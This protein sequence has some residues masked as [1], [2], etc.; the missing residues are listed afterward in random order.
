[1]FGAGA[2]GTYLGGSLALQGHRVA[3]VER[4]QN[5]IALQKNGLRL[6]L[7]DGEY[8][9]SNLEVYSTIQ[10]ATGAGPYEAIIFAIKSYQT[11]EA[12][13]SIKPHVGDLP[14]FICL[15][16]GVDNE[17]ELATVLG[18][19]RI[20]AG[21][22]T[23]SVSKTAPGQVALERLR[24][25]GLAADH[26]LSEKLVE[27]FSDAGL[28]P[29]LYARALDMKWSKLLTNL[30]AN[31]TCAILDMSPSTIFDHPELFELE[32][33]Q[34]REALAVMRA[35]DYRVVDLPGTPVRALAFAARSLNVSLARPLMARAVGRGRGSKMP[36][37]H[38]DLHSGRKQSEVGWLNG[39]V[40]RYGRETGVKTPVNNLLYE[41]L[42]SILEGKT[43]AA[44]YSRNP[45]AL[46]A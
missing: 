18:P 21:T 31:A 36:S 25:V 26:P 7:S 16:N 35:L 13:E 32:I 43:E 19:D 44:L 29:Q 37:L 28:R 42:N 8:L 41:T 45:D 1:V 46:L 27:L 22:V 4:R 24:G 15:Q 40:V 39:A 17:F 10:K 6:R 5:T 33:L 2:I 11:A 12:L 3:F 38:I 14:P 9:V 20:I 23:S 30:L 34:L